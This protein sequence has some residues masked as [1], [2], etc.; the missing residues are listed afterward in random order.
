MLL[1]SSPLGSLVKDKRSTWQESCRESLKRGQKVL[2][3]AEGLKAQGS[4][5]ENTR[6]IIIRGLKRI[7]KTADCL[8]NGKTGSSPVANVT[9]SREDKL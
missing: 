2:V 9:E 7:R 5:D 3:L 1:S 8:R 6:A 4:V